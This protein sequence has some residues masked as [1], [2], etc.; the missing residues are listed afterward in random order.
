MRPW[1]GLRDTLLGASADPTESPLSVQHLTLL[2]LDT[3]VHPSGPTLQAFPASGYFPMS[4]FF[5]SSGQRIGVSTS[6]L[7]MDIQG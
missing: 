5:A 4:Q 3:E 1:D 6:L 7:P 2:T